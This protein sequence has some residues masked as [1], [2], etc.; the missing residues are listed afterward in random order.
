MNP[1][2]LRGHLALLR[3]FHAL[4]ISVEEVQVDSRV[5]QWALDLSKELRWSW[6]VGLA[7]ERWAHLVSIVLK[8]RLIP[9]S[10]LRDGV[11]R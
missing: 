5:P 3:E 2:Q 10:G 7:V 11:G 6:F 8:I 1:E 4:R 9:C